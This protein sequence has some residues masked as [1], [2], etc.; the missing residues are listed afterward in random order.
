M[1][2]VTIHSETSDYVTIDLVCAICEADMGM[3]H[4]PK[5]ML[6]GRNDYCEA[7]K[8]AVRIAKM[9]AAGTLPEL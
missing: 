7:C 3:A 5:S 6:L 9:K 4:M 8:R 2:V 1:R